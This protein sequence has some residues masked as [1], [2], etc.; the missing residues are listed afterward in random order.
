[1]LQA[2]R[3]VDFAHES[4]AGDRLAQRGL[5]DLDRNRTPVF[6]VE[7]AIH[8]GHAAAPNETFDDVLLTARGLE[9]LDLEVQ[10]LTQWRLT[11]W[12]VVGRGQKLMCRRIA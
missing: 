4:I 2:R 8:L 7:R 5:E 6:H 12:Q 9:S 11:F 1:M 3:D 10:V